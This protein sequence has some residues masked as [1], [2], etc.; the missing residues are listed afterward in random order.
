MADN[1]KLR[2]LRGSW[3]N[4]ASQQIVDG[5]V[6]ITTDERAMYVDVGT[7]RLRIGDFRIYEDLAALRTAFANKS[8][9]QECLYYLSKDNILARYDGQNFVQ[10]NAQD[11]L[12]ALIKSFTT[13]VVATESADGATIST[14]I[15]GSDKSKKTVTHTLKSADSDIVSIAVDEATNTIAINV[16]DQNTATT[17]S[18]PDV[19]SGNEVTVNVTDTRTGQNANGTTIDP[20]ESTTSF[21]IAGATG[22]EVKSSNGKITINA[23]PTSITNAFD[24]NGSFTTKIQTPNNGVTTSAAIIP[25]IK[26]GKTTFQEAV[27]TSGT[28]T[29]DTYTTSQ[30][31]ALIAE[32]LRAANA[33]TFKNGIASA[34]EL[35]K[36]NI[37]LGDTYIVTAKGVS[38]EGHVC[39]IGDLFIA[40]GTKEDSQG[41]I[42]EGLTWIYVPAGN[43]DQISV[44]F[45]ATT[46]KGVL[47]TKLGSTV[48]TVGNFAA[49]DGIVLTQN[50]TGNTIEFG[51]GAQ[52]AALTDYTDYE[53]SQTSTATVNKAVQKFSA[54]SDVAFDTYGHVT[55]YTVTEYSIN[56][57]YLSEI[58]VASEATSNVGTI[59]T[60]YKRNNT[61]Q[62]TSSFSI[63]A[64]SN[65]M[66]RI[67]KSGDKGLLVEAVWVDF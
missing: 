32:K 20:V 14:V 53:Q 42:S 33:M 6:Y 51:H 8:P 10:I 17:V 46:E 36:S 29:I 37:S 61:T 41:Y 2:F 67:S 3:E 22:T 38:I 45:S 12:G 11:E 48:Q 62:I 34:S 43:D 50:S 55:G 47:T 7:N 64:T 23:K 30:T 4:L 56:D 49:S 18:V 39:Q 66:L 65:D 5:S 52:Q 40:N 25:K 58:A 44:E 57:I 31:D 60:T 1:A 21:K 19:S 35:P 27:F 54:I 28:A 59:T 24:A 13:T 26:Y 9:S 16:K 15:E 63:E